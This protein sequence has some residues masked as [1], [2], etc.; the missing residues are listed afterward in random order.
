MKSNVTLQNKLAKQN[1]ISRQRLA[2]ELVKLEKVEKSDLRM[3]ETARHRFRSRHKNLEALQPSFESNA[4]NVRMYET[5]NPGFC[6]HCTGAIKKSQTIEQ[7]QTPKDSYEFVRS[8]VF[9]KG[10]VDPDKVLCLHL[11]TAHSTKWKDNDG[12]SIK[13][14]SS[15]LEKAKSKHFSG[16]WNN[17]IPCYVVDTQVISSNTKLHED[18]RKKILDDQ[19]MYEFEE[20]YKEYMKKDADFE[21][22]LSSNAKNAQRIMLQGIDKM[23]AISPHVYSLLGASHEL[24]IKQALA[25]GVAKRKY[26]GSNMKLNKF[27]E[28]NL[29]FRLD[30]DDDILSRTT[31]NLSTR[32]WILKSHSPSRRSTFGSLFKFDQGITMLKSKRKKNQD[33]IPK[34]L[35]SIKSSVRAM[36]EIPSKTSSI[37]SPFYSMFDSRQSINSLLSATLYPETTTKC[38]KR[39]YLNAPIK[40]IELRNKEYQIVPILVNYQLQ[41][42]V[43]TV[44]EVLERVN[45]EKS[46]KIIDTARDT[47]EIN[48]MLLRPEIQNFIQSLLGQSLV[49]SPE[50]FVVSLATMTDEIDLRFEGILEKEIIALTLEMPS[51][52]SLDALIAEIRNNIFLDNKKPE[53]SRNTSTTSS[54]PNRGKVE[55]KKSIKIAY[56]KN[57]SRWSKNKGCSKGMSTHNK[58]KEDDVTQL[59]ETKCENSLRKTSK[60]KAADQLRI[61]GNVLAKRTSNSKSWN[62]AQD[63]SHLDANHVILQRMTNTQRILV[64][65]MCASLKT[66]KINNQG[67]IDENVPLAALIAPAL[68]RDSIKILT[69]GAI[70]SNTNITDEEE[71]EDNIVV[72]D[73]LTGPLLAKIQ[74]DIAEDETNRRLKTFLKNEIL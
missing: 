23:P 60:I 35:I 52:P 59:S 12:S 25:E 6:Y 64:G 53:Q 17:V 4:I 71:I 26:A 13:P 8:I 38:R 51:L 31:T 24:R 55:K 48:K 46:K 74:Q 70:F 56:L 33:T 22:A 54:N 63:L 49:S 16:V 47:E 36:K 45:P 5:H 44:F 66:K 20:K 67:L 10:E 50:S 68:S 61:S 3:I 27:N 15:L 9:T 18:P 43:Q 19:L 73:K 7:E 39:I 28:N 42:L 32:N 69:R 29:S 72:P 62:I 65:Q 40:Y 11:L 34:D 14:I 57:Y 37:K 21:K 30:D 1:E 2:Q 41:A 58:S